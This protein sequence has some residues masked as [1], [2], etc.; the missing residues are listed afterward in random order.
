M[1]PK[2]DFYFDKAHKWELAM[3]QLRIIALDC[4]LTEVL[5]WGVPCYTFQGNNVALLHHFKDYCALLFV[6]GVLLQDTEGIL[7]QQT[8]HSQSSRQLR[9]TSVQAIVEQQATIKAYLYEAIEIQRLG[10]KVALKE[11]ADY[12]VPEEFQRRLTDDTAL[13]AAFEALTPGRQRGY[14][15]HFASAKQSKTRQARIDKCVRAIFEGKGLG[16]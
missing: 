13:K 5:K 9:F 12:N 8:E 4:N 11:T 2:V 15:L 16:E 7:F 14:L 6:K 10:L 3:R 1:N